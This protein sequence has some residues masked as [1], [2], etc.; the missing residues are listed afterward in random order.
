M[1]VV[2]L[3][4]TRNMK[5]WFAVTLVLLASFHFFET[6]AAPRRGHFNRFYSPGLSFYP[7]G[8]YGFCGYG[9]GY[10]GGGLGFGG[11]FG[12]RGRPGRR[13]IRN[14]VTAAVLGGLVRNG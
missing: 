13:L 2:R 9:G 10:Y 5:L 12:R 6:E 8:G 11:G 14:L 3:S 4:A 7:G 1:G